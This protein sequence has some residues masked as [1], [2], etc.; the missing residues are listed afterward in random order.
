MYGQSG[1]PP[2]FLTSFDYDIQELVANTVKVN[3]AADNLGFELKEALDECESLKAR[4][5]KL[6][7]DAKS[8]KGYREEL[9]IERSRLLARSTEDMKAM[10]VCNR[11]N[12]M[13]D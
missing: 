2:E 9:E 5:R 11:S 8:W 12:D 1:I 3:K 6:E 4:I 7:L 13:W 10:K